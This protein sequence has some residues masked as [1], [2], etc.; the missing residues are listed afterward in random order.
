MTEQYQQ[1]NINLPRG[2]QYIDQRIV[3][4]ITGVTGLTSAVRLGT[5]ARFIFCG[6]L[7][8]YNV[9]IPS[10]RA[11]EGLLLNFKNNTDDFVTLYAQEGEQINGNPTL[12]I[13]A[14]AVAVIISDP[15]DNISQP[16]IQPVGWTLFK[17]GAP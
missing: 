7:G 12:V 1:T 9:L 11:I 4:P 2:D 10:V 15:A 3:E 5:D 8:P 6:G 17:N 16:P 14:L 13:A